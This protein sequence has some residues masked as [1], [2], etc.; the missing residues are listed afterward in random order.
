[1]KNSIKVAIRVGFVIIFAF[2]T[3]STRA[4]SKMIK[5]VFRLLPS[6]FIYNLT[7]VTRDSML[8]GKTYYPSENDRNSV[9][10][11]NYGESIYVN[12]YMYIS[13]AYETS[14]RG[15]RMVEIRG[16]KMKEKNLIIV[17]S[18]GGVEGVNYQQIDL[19][20]FIYDGDSSLISCK[21]KIFPD[22]SVDLFLKSGVPDS[23]NKVIQSNINLTFDFSNTNVVLSLNS[24]FLF[25]N[26]LYRKWLKGDCI[27]YAWTGKQF[28][29]GQA[30]FSY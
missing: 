2:G 14:Q 22:W 15:T 21:A 23:I 30:Y 25:D 17:S 16:F 27:R 7:D 13:M 11:F 29:P 4:Q 6:A 10:A 24:S 3:I 5:T 18:T 9:L 20:A 12:D 1:L 26:Q 8:E 19:S 28:K